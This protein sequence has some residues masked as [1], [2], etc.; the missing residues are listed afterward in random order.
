MTGSGSTCGN[1]SMA[2]QGSADQRFRCHPIRWIAMASTTVKG[3]CRC[4]GMAVEATPAG[5]A[6]GCI[7]PTDTVQVNPVAQGAGV[8]NVSG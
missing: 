4:L 3:E 1:V 8:G 6:T 2:N 5:C 7:D